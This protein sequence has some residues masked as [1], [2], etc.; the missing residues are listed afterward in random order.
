D[1]GTLELP[2][3][4]GSVDVDLDIAFE[5]DEADGVRITEIGG[6]PAVP[7]Q[8]DSLDNLRRVKQ[9]LDS[10]NSGGGG[11]AELLD[12]WF[13][14]LNIKFKPS[15]GGSPSK[16]GGAMKVPVNLGYELKL[17]D[18]VVDDGNVSTALS[19]AVPR[20]LSDLPGAMLNAIL[21]N[22]WPVLR[23]ILTSEKTYEALA[24]AI[25]A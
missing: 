2:G 15:L 17:G 7:Q 16:D 23:D 5:W 3:G 18:I 9:L 12:S 20:S 8:L 4:I 10:M 25:G 14:K 24:K 13:G 21:G 1:L 19:F 22:L 11:C 6:L